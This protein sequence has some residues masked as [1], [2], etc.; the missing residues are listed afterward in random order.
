MTNFS[1]FSVL[2]LGEKCIFQPRNLDKGENLKLHPRKFTKF[3]KQLYEIKPEAFDKIFSRKT[4]KNSVNFQG[5]RVILEL[6][7]KIP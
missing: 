4:I 6:G 5:G 1:E 3:F 7:K 2:F